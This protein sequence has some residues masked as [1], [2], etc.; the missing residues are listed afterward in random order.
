MNRTLQIT[1]GVVLLLAVAGG[2][3]YGGMLYGQGQAQA[4]FLARRTGAVPGGVGGFPVDPNQAGSQRRGNA[5]AG[6]LFG[7]ITEIGEGVLVITDSDG[8]QTQV[9]VT[10]TTLIEKNASVTVAELTT[11][12]T[13]IVSGTPGSDGSTTARSGQVAPAGRFGPG[14]GG[15]VVPTGQ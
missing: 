11:G 14:G 12:E 9:K 10:E 13:I 2:S 1:L 7:Q 4:N 8:K 6:S 5:Q 15:F 3:F